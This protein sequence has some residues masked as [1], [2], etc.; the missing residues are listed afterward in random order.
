[1]K[2]SFLVP[3]ESQDIVG[4]HVFKQP[5]LAH[6]A[7][8]RHSQELGSLQDFLCCLQ[9]SQRHLAMVK[10][11]QDRQQSLVRNGWKGEFLETSFIISR[12]IF[13]RQKQALEELTPNSQNDFVDRIFLLCLCD[14]DG[15][16]VFMTSLRNVLRKMT[17]VDRVYVTN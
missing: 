12:V 5:V 4:V 3:D 16:I 7:D 11:M 14:Q 17:R 10:P 8:R 6:S 1:M 15:I 2:I 13:V 9:T